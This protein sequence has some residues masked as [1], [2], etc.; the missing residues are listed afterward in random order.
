MWQQV[1]NCL[2]R[3]KGKH[4]WCSVCLLDIPAL[5]SCI[6]GTDLLNCTCC[7]TERDVD[8]SHTVY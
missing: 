7:H 5:C 3:A 2:S 1:T 8:I 6:R 4:S